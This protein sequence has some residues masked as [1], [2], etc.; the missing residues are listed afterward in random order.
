LSENLSNTQL[1][2]RLLGA[3]ILV[4][5]AIIVIPLFLGDPNYVAETEPEASKNTAFESRIQPLPDEVKSKQEPDASENAQGG[6]LVL[7]KLDSE[8]PASAEKSKQVVIQPLRLDKSDSKAAAK[9]E[10]VNE[11]VAKA[12]PQAV[13]KK[14]TPAKKSSSSVKPVAKKV[15]SGW[16]VQAGIFSKSVNARAIADILKSNGYAPN[17]SDAKASFG[18]AKRVWIGPFAS[19]SEAQTVSKRL[20]QQ[21]GNGGYVAVYPFKS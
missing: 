9:P 19:K 20:E 8:Q 5:I 4:L 10:M 11:A 16:A 14:A 21:T 18:P 3:G 17:I 12:K 6:G 2:H 13:A 1:K 7:K 15:S